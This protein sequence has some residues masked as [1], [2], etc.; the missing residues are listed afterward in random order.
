MVDAV[1]DPAGI[2]EPPNMPVGGLLVVAVLRLEN[3][4]L[5]GLFLSVLS[6]SVGLAAPKMEGA[7]GILLN[8]LF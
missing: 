1:L 7:G 2:L 6:T 4:L 8:K 3:I 5:S